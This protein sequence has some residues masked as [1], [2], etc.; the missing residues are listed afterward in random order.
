MNKKNKLI[1]GMV[2]I[3]VTVLLV[4]VGSATYTRSVPQGVIPGLNVGSSGNLVGSDF[5]R[6]LCN[7]A[8]QDFIIQ[9]APAGCESVPVRSDLLE[10]NN[11]QVF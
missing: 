6:E 11:V 1:F 4:S 10:E 7:E 2:L 3:A 9:I 5:S 8:G